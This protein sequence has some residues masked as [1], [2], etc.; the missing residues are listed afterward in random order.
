MVKKLT[1]IIINFVII[2][3][4]LN[5]TYS[6][7]VFSNKEELINRI[8]ESSFTLA[9]DSMLGRGNGQRGLKIAEKYIVDELN[10]I[11][12]ERT[13]IIQKVP[14]IEILPTEKSELQI[15]NM[16]GAKHL[17]LYDDY[18]IHSS[19]LMKYIPNETD[20][21][22]AGYGI[23]A[24][25]FDYNDYYNLNI[26]GKIVMIF[27]GAPSNIF[28]QKDSAKYSVWEFKQRTALA[29][30]AAALIIIPKELKLSKDK[31][32][33]KISEYLRPE[34]NLVSGNN[35]ITTIVINP[36]HIQ[37]LFDFQI[38]E[39]DALEYLGSKK[40][41]IN[42]KIIFKPKYKDRSFTISNILY[43]IKGKDKDKNDECI[44]LSAHYDH[45]GFVKNMTPDSIFNGYQDNALGCS[46][47][48]EI[49]RYYS[50]NVPERSVLIFFTAG[51]EIGLLGSKYYL[52]N[53]YYPLYKTLA[54]VNVDGI[55]FIDEFESIIGLGSEYSN[56]EVI[57][58]YVAENKSLNVDIIDNEKYEMEAFSRSDQIAFAY[59]GIPS[60]LIL[61]G[62]NYKNLTK[63]Q[64]TQILND[65]FINY[66]H[67]PYDDNNQKIN[68]DAA[69]QH[70][71]VILD[72]ADR[73]LNSDF[74]PEWYPNNRFYLKRIRTEVEKR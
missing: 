14:V 29:R 43:E 40:P 69:L 30:G 39:K 49:A 66:Y 9:S 3:F 70:L 2:L 34:Y 22:Y 5:R 46:F 31:W 33:Y 32:E 57:L 16:L 42:T 64:G 48:L 51:E 13:A 24:P 6:I 27:D 68:W 7:V 8:K 71:N 21:V 4:F 53:P 56:L 25:E 20:L 10:K 18:L 72:F 28:S 59:S 50:E 52:N 58:K 11:S 15:I 19:G 73:I 67:T 44:I 1:K 65:Y 60:I 17:K 74:I 26:T 61:D 36:I 62:M 45:L 35:S 23:F 37:D 38:P 41:S 12:K 54:N 63:E 47:L 55:A